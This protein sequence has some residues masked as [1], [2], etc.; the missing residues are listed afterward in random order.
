M[1]KMELNQAIKDEYENTNLAVYIVKVGHMYD[2]DLSIVGVYG[3]RERAEWVAAGYPEY[4]NARVTE[5][6]LND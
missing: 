6:V 4:E 3:S 5:Y 1:A 2:E